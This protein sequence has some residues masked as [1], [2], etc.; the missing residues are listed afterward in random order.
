MRRTATAPAIVKRALP[1]TVERTAPTVVTVRMSIP[2]GRSGGWERWFLLSADRHHDNLHSRHDLE[3]KHLERARE[4]DAGIM[5]FGDLACAMQGKWD[6]RSDQSQMRPEHRVN[7]YLDALVT[8]AADFYQPWAEQWVLMSRGN[9]ETSILRHHQTDLTERLAA[10]LNDRTGSGIMV[11]TY[12]GWVRFAF[13]LGATH[14]ESVRLRYIHGYGG[15]G[16]VTKDLIQANRQAAILGNADII[17]SGHTHDAW[18]V[19]HMR[20][21]L[22]HDGRPQVRELLALK[23]P[24]Y[25]DEYSCGEGYHIEK[26]RGPKPLGCYLLKFYFDDGELRYDALRLK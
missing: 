15:G 13:H 9:H 26:G 17:A 21:Y 18:D 3:R 2:N 23:I 8:T 10:T 24:G 12:A 4:L 25:K 19:P 7:R 22:G 11:G 5:D 20:E 6:A 16:P 1:F 14:R